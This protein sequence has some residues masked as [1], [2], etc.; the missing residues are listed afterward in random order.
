MGTYFFPL[1]NFDLYSHQHQTPPPPSISIP[2]PLHPNSYISLF[3][4]LFPEACTPQLPKPL[5][6]KHPFLHVTLVFSLIEFIMMEVLETLWSIQ[7]KRLVYGDHNVHRCGSGAQ[8]D[9]GGL[10]IF[11]IEVKLDIP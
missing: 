1:L 9:H 8:D 10:W 4:F 5:P 11:H 7:H 3:P 2:T 6:I